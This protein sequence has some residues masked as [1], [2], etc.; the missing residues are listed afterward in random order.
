MD[1]VTG[2]GS[3][4][5]FDMANIVFEMSATLQMRWT[6][7]EPEKL[8]T[9]FG[10]LDYHTAG[11]HPGE[12]T[13][14]AARP[15]VGKS[16]FAVQLSRNMSKHD[17]HIVIFSREM[18][19]GQIAERLLAN[20]S[21]VDGHKLRFA[22]ELTGEDKDII[23]HTTGEMMELPIVINDE[24]ATVQEIRS[25]CRGLKN[26]G[27]LDV[28]IVDYLQMCRTLAK[29]QTRE[30]EVADMS[31]ALKTMARELDIPVVVLAQ[32]NRESV[33]DKR[34]PGLSDLRDS[35]AIEQDADNVI[36]LHVP[37]DTD[38]KAETF[39]IK[40]IIAKQRNGATGS[41]FLNYTRKLFKFG[42]VS[43]RNP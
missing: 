17:N 21:N 22:K 15:G 35:G 24:A 26:R 38:E 2:T 28:A 40:V 29:T 3:E 41:L 20:M 27:R 39:E 9:G 37:A 19:R 36:F 34:Q 31:W 25:F 1:A 5:R 13:I 10:D 23:G 43:R 30:R 12:M 14:I 7:K 11:L 4:S 33:K 6:N 32:L 18:S 16:A 42:S 8:Y